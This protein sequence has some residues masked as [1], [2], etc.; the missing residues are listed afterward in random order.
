[1]HSSVFRFTLV[2]NSPLFRKLFVSD[3]LLGRSETFLY[4][5]SA[6]LQKIVLLLDA[7]QLLMSFCMDVDVFGNKIDSLIHIYNGS[8]WLLK[9]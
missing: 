5:V 6:F 4:L 9:H 8:V 1:M 3:F 7:F 2:L